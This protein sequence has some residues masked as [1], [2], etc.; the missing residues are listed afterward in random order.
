[1]KYNNSYTVCEST[2]ADSR[3]P[4]F[5]NYPSQLNETTAKQP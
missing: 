1:M 2:T 3:E 5:P 4:A